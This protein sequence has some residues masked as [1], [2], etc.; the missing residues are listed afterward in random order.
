MRNREVNISKMPHLYFGAGSTTY[1]Q[2]LQVF[3]FAFATLIAGLVLLAVAGDALVRGGVSIARRFGVPEIIVGL[4]IISVGTSAPELFVSLEAAIAGSAD[5]AIG[6]VV[7]SNIANVLVVLGLPALLAAVAMVEPGIR[8]SVS[9]MSFITLVFILLILDGNL[10]R[11]DGGL[12]LILFGGYLVYSIHAARAGRAVAPTIDHDADGTMTVPRA[13][14]FLALGLGG[15]FFGGQLTVEGALGIAAVFN[16]AETSV[17]TTIVALGTTL[18]EVAATLAAGRRGSAGVAI[19]N[20]IGSNIFNILGI[21]GLVS[22]VTPMAVD[23][24]LFGFDVWVMLGASL[25]L[26]AFAFSRK[27]IGWPIGALL[28][29]AY[30]GYLY[31]ALGGGLPG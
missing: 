27:P 21:L 30:F 17:G 11:I 28:I 24:N 5:L 1:A 22:L 10:T 19:G 12:L 25:L 13:L 18:P 14:L 9:Y 26:L 2:T 15:L 8:R 23:P 3:M 16:L 4:T 31:I 29:A 7:G 6:N 20:I